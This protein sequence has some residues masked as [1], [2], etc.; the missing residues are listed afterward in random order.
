MTKD[1]WRRFIAIVLLLLLA[2]TA[3]SCVT[4]NSETPVW[5]LPSPSAVPDQHPTT[6]M[7]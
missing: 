7:G 3:A 2:A 1:I 4:R 5:T 6:G